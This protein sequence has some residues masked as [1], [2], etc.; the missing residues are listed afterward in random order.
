MHALVMSML[1]FFSWATSFGRLRPTQMEKLLPIIKTFKSFAVRFMIV[2][3]TISIN[4]AFM[5]L[6]LV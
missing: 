3:N 5:F 4:I 6:H 1:C 2:P